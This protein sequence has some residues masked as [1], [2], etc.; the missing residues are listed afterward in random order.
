MAGDIMHDIIETCLNL[1]KKAAAIFSS[2]A[3][4]AGRDDMRCFWEMVAEETNH[5]CATFDRLRSEA[6]NYGPSLIVY[7]PA[8]TREE[9][10]MIEQGVDEQLE[11]YKAAPT[12]EAACLLGFRLQ[13]YLLHPAF[14]SLCRMT[15]DIT[16]EDA[17]GNGYGMY[18]RRFI[19]G[20][21]S[22]G[23]GTPETD[24]LGEALFRLWIEGRQLAAQSHL[25]ALTG[26]LTRAGFFQAISPLAHAAQRNGSNAAVMLLDLDYFKLLGESQGHQTG[27]RVLQVVADTITSHL[28]RSD[29]VG[30][31][32]GDE[33]IVFLSP[34]E[35]AALKAVAE[36]I[37]VRVEEATARF[38]PV[39]ISI[40]VAQGPLG[41]DVDKG[42]EELVRKADECQMQAK[43]TG[44]NKVVIK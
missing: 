14:A 34:V 25:D 26:V 6:A 12:P 35:P 43:Y 42:V 5:H 15:K 39:T 30:R 29:V 22:C 36:N 21:G 28:R 40:G 10:E 38:V 32:D 2:F 31:Y 17:N 37:R 11:R 13:L 44:K 4:D 7:K 33:F 9:L 3:A 23:M 20:I 18:L 27:D 16:G 19:D 24:L 41:D 8:E 1:E